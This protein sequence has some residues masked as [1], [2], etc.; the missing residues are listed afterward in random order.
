MQARGELLGLRK[1][2]VDLSSGLI[3]VPRSHG[4]ETTKGGR[5]E[6]IPMDREL[7]PYVQQA[8][9][10]SPA[11]STG[12]WHPATCSRRSTGSADRIT[13]EYARR[14][15]LVVDEAHHLRA[16]VLLEDYACSPTT[17]WTRRTGSR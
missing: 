15:V 16:D 11:E 8:L 14:P 13:S 17:R 1:S 2:D 4:R 7:V 9:A 6:A 3:N 12:T 5:A 10:R